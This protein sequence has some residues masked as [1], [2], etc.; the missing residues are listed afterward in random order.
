MV[1]WILHKIILVISQRQANF[2]QFNGTHAIYLL[3][4]LMVN[5]LYLIKSKSLRLF[6][7]LTYLNK[8]FSLNL[9]QGD[10]LNKCMA[11]FVT[12]LAYLKGVASKHLNTLSEN[13]A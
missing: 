2:C 4:I 9:K 7:C 11:I 1:T 10:L 3:V 12:I 13:I 5:M 8:L 6:D